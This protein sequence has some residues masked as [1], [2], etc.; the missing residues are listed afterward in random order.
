MRQEPACDQCLIAQQF[1]LA[2]NEELLI[3]RTPNFSYGKK[4][5]DS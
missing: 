3:S 5:G 1:D 4:Q 2:L